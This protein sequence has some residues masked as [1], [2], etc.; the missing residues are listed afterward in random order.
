M[1][2]AE[3]VGDGGGINTRVVIP[4]RTMVEVTRRRLAVSASAV[5]PPF[6]SSLTRR[7]TGSQLSKP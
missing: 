7:G 5:L 1:S 4:L 2:R 3:E 6:P